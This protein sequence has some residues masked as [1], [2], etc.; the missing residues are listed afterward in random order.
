MKSSQG[1][2]M[3]AMALALAAACSDLALEP[4]QIPHSIAISPEDARVKVGDAGEFT[5]TVFDEDGQVIPGPPSWAPADWEVADPSMVEFSPGGAFTALDNG[6]AR[7]GAR[8]AGLLARTTLLIS[9]GSVRLTAPAMYLNQVAQ[10]LDGTVPLIAGRDALLRVFV[11]GDEVSYYEPRAYADFL[12]DGEVIH[13]AAMG[14]PHVIPDAVTEKWRLQSFNAE[15]PGEVI[16]PGVELFVEMD[17]DGV[18]P[19][20]SGSQARIPAEGALELNVIELPV[21]FQT[22]VPV[23]GETDPREQIRIWAQD[24]TAGHEWLQFARSVLPI[25]DMHL[26]VHDPFYTSVDLGTFD[27]WLQLISDIRT[28]RTIENGRGYYYGAFHRAN[29]TG[30]VGLGYIGWPVSIGLSQDETFAHEVGH[31]MSLRHAPCGNVAGPDP[32][33]PYK[34]GSAGVWGYDPASGG[35]IDPDQYKDLMGYCDP[36]WVSDYSFTKALDYRIWTEIGRGG[37]DPADERPAEQTLLLRGRAV[38]GELMLE[39]AFLVETRPVLPEGDGPYRLEGFGSGGRVVFSFDFTPTPLEF[40]G[41]DFL[42]AL[43]YDAESDGTLERVVVSGPEGEFALG[44]SSTSPMAIII[45]RDNGQVR[46]ILRD[47]NGGLGLVDGNTEIL[48]SD[49]LPDECQCG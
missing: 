21:H 34:D 36:S 32:R 31:N 26:T 40:G 45:N 9:P 24:L 8:S 18:V 43:P 30:I 35:I 39:P 41:G 44:P 29:L 13:T 28:L 11:T 38:N 19:L 17:P 7:I 14:P 49:G 1:T 2:L 42:F 23:I 3:T 10:R 46:A 27:G 20:K 5:V 22:L 25:G 47:W 37:V 15:I 16:Q 48:V 4:N 33:F 6:E 12:R